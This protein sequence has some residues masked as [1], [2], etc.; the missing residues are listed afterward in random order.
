MSDIC[1][2]NKKQEGIITSST[3]GDREGGCCRIQ[4]CEHRHKKLKV[5]LIHFIH[6]LPKSFILITEQSSS[7]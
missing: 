3:M 1:T 4:Y 6:R 2:A 7:M 5:P